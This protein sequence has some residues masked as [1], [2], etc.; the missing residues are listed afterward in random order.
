MTNTRKNVQLFTIAASSRFG[1]GHGYWYG[2]SEGKDA[3]RFGNLNPVVWGTKEEAT[4]EMQ[5][6]VVFCEEKN[7]QVDFRLE[8]YG[9]PCDVDYDD[10]GNILHIHD[11]E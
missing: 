5:K 6:A 9:E 4:E 3:V 8:T 7:W 11:A 10:A 2:T 1:D